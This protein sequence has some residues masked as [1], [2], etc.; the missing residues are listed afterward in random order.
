MSRMKARPAQHE[1][2]HPTY[3]DGISRLM[4]IAQVLLGM[5]TELS[6]G[7]ANSM[8]S[9]KLEDAFEALK[10]VKLPRRHDAPR[11]TMSDGCRS[12]S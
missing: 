2:I 8:T 12:T 9:G 1:Q 10:D 11:V 4:F 6:R 5:L 7:K 3:D